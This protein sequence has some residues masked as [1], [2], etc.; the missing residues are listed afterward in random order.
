MNN[1]EDFNHLINDLN[2]DFDFLGISES[3]ILQSQ[4][5]NTNVSLQ[6]YLTEQSPTESN[7]GGFLLHISKKN[8]YKTWQDLMIDKSKNLLKSTFIEVILPKKSNLA[9]GVQTSIYGYTHFQW[10]SP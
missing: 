6:N 7:A 1:F 5:L 2:L 10:S 3:R 8:S 4:P 9:L